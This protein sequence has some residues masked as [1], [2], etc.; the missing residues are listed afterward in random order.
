MN[1]VCLAASLLALF[2]QP[3]DQVHREVGYQRA[4]SMYHDEDYNVSDQYSNRFLEKFNVPLLSTMAFVT[5]SLS[6]RSR[7][8]V[9]MPELD[10]AAACS[11]DR[12]AATILPT[13][14]VGTIPA[15]KSATIEPP[16]GRRQHYNLGSTSG[17]VTYSQQ[18]RL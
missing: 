6:A 8:I 18:H 11:S 9:S 2:T 16:L 13:F 15:R 3:I 7:R 12:T 5:A 17:S 10:K 4:S 14:R 1:E